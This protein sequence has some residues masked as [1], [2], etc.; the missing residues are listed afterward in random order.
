MGSTAVAILKSPSG[1][2]LQYALQLNYDQCTNN[3]A[4]YEG[5]LL[6]LQKAKA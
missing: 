4:E 1:I 2:K 5:L 3:V 6:T